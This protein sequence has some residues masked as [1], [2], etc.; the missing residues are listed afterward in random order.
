MKKIKSF[1]LFFLFINCLEKEL[2][3]LDQS[4]LNL[5][6]ENGILNY[7]DKPFSGKIVS[8]YSSK[9]KRVDI[10]YLNGRKNGNEKKWYKSGEIASERNYLNNFKI[11]VHKG[12]WENGKKKFL[13]HFNFKGEYMG[14][15]E[16][17]YN[18][19]N[20][21][22]FFNYINGKEVGNQKLWHETG[23]VKANYD[24]VDGERY[25]LIG[26]KNCFKVNNGQIVK[27]NEWLV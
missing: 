16:E 19:G 10:N 11:G 17:W 23:A 14:T 27:W 9:Q 12:Y 2:I 3:I 18:S 22:R 7:F 25:G 1:L 5:K 15:V 21:Y 26:L 4:D 6:T 24:V 13:Y 8:F 20:K